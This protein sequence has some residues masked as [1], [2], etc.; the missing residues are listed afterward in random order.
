MGSSV[1]LTVLS[2]P[3]QGAHFRFDGLF[4]CVLGRAEDCTLVFPSIGEYLSI[5][6]RHCSLTIDPPVV[7]LTDLGSR[8]GTFVNGRKVGQRRHRRVNE[9]TTLTAEREM[10][11]K[12]ADVIRLADTDIACQIFHASE[13]PEDL[14]V[15]DPYSS[16][17]R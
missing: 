12:S 3:L 9:R 8:N 4:L 2:G 11:L 5:S 17:V 1:V 14:R 13:I 15:A 6:R 16:S 7:R 10:L